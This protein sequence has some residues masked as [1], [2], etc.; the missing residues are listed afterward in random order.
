MALVHPCLTDAWTRIPS[1]IVASRIERD[2]SCEYLGCTDSSKFNYDATATILDRCIAFEYGCRNPNAINYDAT[3]N[4]DDGSCIV[5]GCTDE[6]RINYDSMA[7]TNDGSCA[8]DLPG[9]TNPKANNYNALYNRND[10]SCRIPG[11]TDSTQS[12]YDPE[13]NYDDGTC[14]PERRRRML[15]SS[16]TGCMDPLASNFDS[17]ATSDAGCIYPIVGCMNS[18]ATN[19]FA[20]ATIPADCEFVAGDVRYPSER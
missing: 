13:A 3:V 7:N 20:A 8:P 17:L 19:Y 1:P 18:L 15:S 9:C 5:L 6:T 14:D 11:C 2:G 12:A 10:G 4:T 16:T